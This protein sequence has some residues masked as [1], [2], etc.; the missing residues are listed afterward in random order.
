M[1]IG[2]AKME[3]GFILVFKHKG[4][5]EILAHTASNEEEVCLEAER[6]ELAG[7]SV[8]YS[9]SIFDDEVARYW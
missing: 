8:L 3:S 4:T 2:K 7:H 6:V 9:L 5:G 1:T